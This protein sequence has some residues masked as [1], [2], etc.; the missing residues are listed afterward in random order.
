MNPHRQEVELRSFQFQFSY[1]DQP[2]LQGGNELYDPSVLHRRLLVDDYINEFLNQ[3]EHSFHL[4]VAFAQLKLAL[5]LTGSQKS[6]EFLFLDETRVEEHQAFHS[7]LEDEIHFIHLANHSVS[8]L[9]EIFLGK[10]VSLVHLSTLPHV[11]FL[12]S[13]Q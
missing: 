1:L 5:N 2:N 10:E 4:Q 12:S 3:P 8:R 6:K 7:N 11:I 13:N 9:D